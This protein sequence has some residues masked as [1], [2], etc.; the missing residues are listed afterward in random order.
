RAAGQRPDTYAARTARP[1]L[2]AHHSPNPNGNSAVSDRGA[3]L[4]GHLR[5]YRLYVQHDVDPAR[6]G[7]DRF[8]PAGADLGRVAGHHQSRGVLVADA[9]R[10]TADLD[11]VRPTGQDAA[12]RPNVGVPPAAQPGEQLHHRSPPVA[13]MAWMTA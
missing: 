2:L 7:Q 6:V 12:G 5:W 13:E 9:Y 8:Q 1:V 4:R 3:A 11:R 10:P